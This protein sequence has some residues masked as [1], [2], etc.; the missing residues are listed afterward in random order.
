[1]MRIL[2]VEVC[3]L[4]SSC[5]APS[6]LRKARAPAW[7]AAAHWLSTDMVRATNKTA[8]SSFS[9]SHQHADQLARNQSQPPNCHQP[10]NPAN[11]ES[12]SLPGTLAQHRAFSR[13]NSPVVTLPAIALSPATLITIIRHPEDDDGDDD[14]GSRA[15]ASR[16][17]STSM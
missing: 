8:T 7:P 14:G 13:T 4:H 1:M 17:T 10:T 3:L 15:W 5:H 9:A 2:P 12:S 6:P 11:R 16:L